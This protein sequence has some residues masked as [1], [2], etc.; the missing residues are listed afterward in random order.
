MALTDEDLKYAT[1]IA[2]LDMGLLNEHM[3]MS[4]G[5]GPHKVK[6]LFQFPADG[7]CYP[8]EYFDGL[9]D[10]KDTFG[11]KIVSLDAGKINSLSPKAQDWKVV[12]TFDQNNEGQ[13]GFYGVVIDTG[14]DLIVTFRGSEPPSELQNIHQDWLEADIALLEGQLTDQQQDVNRFLDHLKAEGYFDK[15]DNI[16]FAG[17]SL[18]G[19]LA[20]HATFYA[21]KIGV[22]DSI[23]RTIS[24]DGP[25]FAQEYLDANRQYIDLATGTVQM[26]HIEQSLVGAL[27]QRVDGI[28]YMFAD[29]IGSG[30]VQHGTE[31]VNFDENGNIIE[32]KRTALAKILAP[33]TQGMDRLTGPI[34]ASIMTKALVAITAGVWGIKDALID[35]NGNLTTVGKTIVTTLGV[36]LAA[37]LIKVGPLVLLAAAVPLAVMAVKAL[38]V[39]AA[40]AVAVIAYE[41]I[42]DAVDAVEAFV[43]HVVT[44]LIPQM[45]TQLANEIAKFANWTKQQLAEFGSMLA[46]GYRTLA[47]GL[48]NLF[49]APPR[50]AASSH[51]R[52]DTYKLRHY[53]QRLS[54][55]G[56]RISAVDSNLNA[57]Y[58]TEGFLDII[59]LAIAENLPSRGQI[60]KIVNYLED[61]ASE[62]DGAE[63][64]IM[65]I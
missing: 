61:T 14:D 42:M 3:P 8:Q 17:H 59:N 5:N 6:D 56:S 62:F 20:E 52:V 34:G 65:S 38:V 21:A 12:E 9:I 27:L 4:Y 48:S 32:G 36:G 60:N 28:D 24:Y 1:D 58:F 43:A 47:Q 25:G 57:L 51:I 30:P 22:A 10:G 55:V 35:E 11:D 29:L 26:D 16:S 18:G 33:F 50:V 64:R 31:N 40:F 15:Y 63:N 44:E 53:A 45:L 7:A 19:N 13:S 2:Y 54:T 41:Y 46:S 23:D 37:V 49:G 39:V